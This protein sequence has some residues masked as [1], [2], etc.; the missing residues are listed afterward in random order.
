MIK[1]RRI[2]VSPSQSN[3]DN[4]HHLQFLVF[5]FTSQIE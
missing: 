1:K 5:Q 3:Q 2:L 4:E